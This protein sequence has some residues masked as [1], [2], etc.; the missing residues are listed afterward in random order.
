MLSPQS[1]EIL[2]T[3]TPTSFQLLVQRL[4]SLELHFDD[5]NNLDVV[6]S[7]LSDLFRKIFMSADNMQALHIGF[8]SHR[9]LN[10]PLDDIFHNIRWRQLAAFGIQA[11][12][13]DAEEIVALVRRHRDRLRGLRLRD[14]LLKDGSRW[15]DVLGFLRSEVPHLE[16]VSLRRIGYAKTFDEQWAARGAE[17]PDDP[18]GGAPSDS[19]EEDMMEIGIESSDDDNDTDDDTS[20]EHSNDSDDTDEDDDSPGPH[21]QAHARNGTRHATNGRHHSHEEPDSADETDDEHGPMAET[22]SFPART[23]AQSPSDADPSFGSNGAVSTSSSALEDLG[24][25]GIF[26]SNAQRKTW[27]KWVVPRRYARGHASSRSR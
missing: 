18:P 13:L 6:M 7:D 22:M 26:V 9:P 21:I 5:G 12:K 25:N 4:T 14:V 24:D 17:I 19:D 11:W 27:E 8:P 3:K 10:L 20:D 16:W 15:Q 2:A 1:A 23:V